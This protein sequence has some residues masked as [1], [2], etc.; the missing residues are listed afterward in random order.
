MNVIQTLKMTAIYFVTWRC[1]YEL[2]SHAERVANH[3]DILSPNIVSNVEAGMG[4][5]LA[6]VAR[7]ER[8]WARLY[9]EF[10]TDFAGIDLLI[11]PGNAVSPFL[12]ADGI[13][14]SVG[15]KVMENYVEEA[16]VRPALTLTG[17][18]RDSNPSGA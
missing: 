18:H 9:A 11:V 1:V 16:L 2:A 3:R 17:Q 7:A 12:I 15:G 14:K 10:Q 4:M 6:D 5:S 13:P 8:D